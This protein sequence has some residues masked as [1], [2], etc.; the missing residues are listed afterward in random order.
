M[1]ATVLS[2]DVRPARGM[3]AAGLA[4]FTISGVASQPVIVVGGILHSA[5]HP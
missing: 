5:R 1:Y 4:G 2:P 3:G